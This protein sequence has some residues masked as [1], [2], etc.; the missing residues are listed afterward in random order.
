MRKLMVIFAV[1][2]FAGCSNPK[3]I[4]FGPEPLK[5]IAEQGD[6]FKKLSEEDRAL[7]VGYLT[8]TEMGK[9]FGADVKPATGR[10][11]GEVLVD[12]KAWKEK[13]KAAEAEEK[14]KEAEVEALRNK[15]L[16]ERKAIADKISTSVVVAIIDKTVLPKNFEVGLYSE[17]LSLK[18]AIENKSDKTIRQLKGRVTFKDAIG[19]EIGWLSV[20]IDEPVKSGQTLKTTTG[21]GWKINPFMNGEIEKIAGREF[22]SMKATFEPESIAFEDGEVLKAPD[23]P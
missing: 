2:L 19:D 1:A 23:L 3:D 16:A 18:Y 10:T 17:M 21:R 13:M 6:Q 15:V 11:V 5:Q 14:K 4:V 7:L 9:A 22:S 8:I 20:D 12:A